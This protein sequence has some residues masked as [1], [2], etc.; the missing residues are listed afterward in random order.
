MYTNRVK[1]KQG[2]QW[3]ATE[4]MYGM[5]YGKV[6]FGSKGK[7]HR[8]NSNSIGHLP[9]LTIWPCGSPG[10]ATRVISGIEDE[11]APPEPWRD[12]WKLKWSTQTTQSLFLAS[13]F[14]VDAFYS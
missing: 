8:E 11:I 3:G 6:F 7:N 12:L 14:Y 2:P 5:K 4:I 1:A 13:F 9:V 10:A